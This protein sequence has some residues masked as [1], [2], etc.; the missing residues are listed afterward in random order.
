[1]SEQ[2]VGVLLAAGQSRRFGS[3]KLLHPVVDNT[4]MLLVSAQKLATALPR[5]LVVI[6]NDL[7]DYRAQLEQLG[8]QVVINEHAGQG[9]G[10]SIACGVAASADASGWLIA[11]ADMPCINVET[12]QTIANGLNSDAAIVAPQ[13]QQQRGHPVAFARQFKEALIALNEDTGARDIIAHHEDQLELIST[14]D[15]GVI[16]DIDEKADVV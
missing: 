16:I 15:K 8:L 11:L 5:S 14:V 6:N 1:M 13:Y 4:P 12:I 2:P 3:N 7:L 10:S 9:M